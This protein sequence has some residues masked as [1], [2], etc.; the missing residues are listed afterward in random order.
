MEEEIIATGIDPLRHAEILRADLDFIMADGSHT[1]QDAHSLLVRDLQEMGDASV[2]TM[3]ALEK[4][5]HLLDAPADEP[6]EVEQ[7][8]QEAEVHPHRVGRIRR[9]LRRLFHAITSRDGMIIA[10]TTIV[11]PLIEAARE[12]SQEEQ[13]E[14]EAA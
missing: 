10:A 11:P 13:E 12:H 3:Q 6:K 5:L 14:R 8:L 2:P 4:Y 7:P 9:A 1:E